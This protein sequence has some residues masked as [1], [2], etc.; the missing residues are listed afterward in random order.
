MLGKGKNIIALIPARA[1]SKG[2]VGKNIR[3]LNGKPLIAY[4]IEA[5][6][7]CKVVS[8]VIV[9]TDSEEIAAIAKK[10]GAEV[11]F[12]R[13]KEIASDTT[14]DR[15]VMEHCINWLKE[16]ENYRPDYL[17]YLRPTTPFK[18]AD[19][20]QNCFKMI[21]KTIEATSL[22]TI[23][24]SVGVYHPYWMFKPNNEKLVPFI[25][26]VSIK[27]YYQR[28]MLP[29]CFRLNGVVDIL[30]PDVFM[31]NKDIYGENMIG[32]EIDEKQSVDIDTEFDLKFAEFLIKEREE[33]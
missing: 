15:Q 18:T 3:L 29:K 25:E 13:P 32:F 11:P 4:S 22:R 31:K 20:I 16:N 14:P 9:S 10:Y 5:A 21:L 28:Q 7:N 1:G 33:S 19:L 17:A 2:V 24:I 26:G 12:I 6:K 8:R 27:N 30:R 23:T